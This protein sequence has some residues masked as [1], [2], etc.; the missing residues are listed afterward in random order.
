MFGHHAK[1]RAQNTTYIGNYFQG[2]VPQGNGFNTAENFLADVPNGG[3]LIARYNI[4]AKNA[5]GPDSNGFSLTY[6]TEGIPNDG[7]NGQP[8]PNSIDVQFNTFV[9]F[10]KTYDGVHPVAPLLFFYP[11]QSPADAGFPVSNVTVANNAFVGY[12]PVDHVPDY[13]GTTQ[14]VAGFG[15][16]SQVFS[17]GGKF[18]APTFNVSGQNT[19]SHQSLLV[20]RQKASIGA[21]D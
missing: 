5:S 20:P 3:A 19:Y 21:E 10:T 7:P 17:F 1:S 2:G 6:A 11:G 4:F 16:L 9:A 12:C 8:R 14:L 15:D 18:V 13:R